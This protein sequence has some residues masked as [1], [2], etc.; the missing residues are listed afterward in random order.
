[1]EKRGSSKVIPENKSE[2]GGKKIENLK[3]D[4]VITK[5][6]EG[7]FTAECLDLDIVTEGETIQEVRKNVRKAVE[8]HL[9]VACEEGLFEQIISRVLQ[10][11]KPKLIEIEVPSPCSISSATI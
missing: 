9:K 7:G 1:M 8:L 10:K 6:P 5:Q 11:S 2:T 3:I 4:I